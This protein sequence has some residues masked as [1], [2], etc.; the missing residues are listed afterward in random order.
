LFAHGPAHFNEAMA[1]AVHDFRLFMDHLLAEGAPQ[2]AV[3]GLSLGGY[4]SSIL[5]AVEERLTVVVPNAPVTRV[6]SLARQWFPANILLDAGLWLGRIPWDEFEAALDVTSPLNYHPVVPRER[7]MIIGGLGDRLAPPE[8][9]RWLWEH[10]DR[11]RLHWF[12]GN[13]ILHAGRGAYLK[14][15]L[16]FMRAAG[17][18]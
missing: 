7:R 4:V 10:W 16:S 12:P 14:E 1:H 5:A 8:Q 13:H 6:A 9:S 15:M 3:T 2:V 17:F 11:P 18:R